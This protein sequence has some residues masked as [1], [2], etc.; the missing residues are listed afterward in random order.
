MTMRFPTTVG[1]QVWLCAGLLGLSAMVATAAPTAP[2]A[3]A[4]QQLFDDDWRWQM[5]HQPEFASSMGE[6]AAG[7]RWDDHSAAALDAEEAHQR[8]LMKRLQAIPGCP[9]PTG[10]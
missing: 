7:D 8:A 5:R 1:W 3:R 2:A 10:W 9:R 6:R 4:L